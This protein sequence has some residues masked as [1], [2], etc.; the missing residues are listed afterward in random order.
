MFLG[1]KG[2]KD[3]LWVF[4][5][6]LAAIACPLLAHAGDATRCEEAYV[7][8]PAGAIL[9]LLDPDAPGERRVRALQ[10]YERLATMR[11]CPEFGY[12]L[13]QLYRHGPEL[14]GNLVGEDI[15]KAKELIQAMA[16][17]GYL[18]AFADL[19]EMVMREGEHREAMLWT[20]VYLHLVRTVQRP[21]VDADDA[22]FMRTAYN[23]HLLTRAETVWRW[24][25]PAVP[26]RRVTE[27]LNAWLSE[28]GASVH[29]RMTERQQGSDRR[30]SAQDGPLPRVLAR[31]DDC[32][33]ILDPRIGAATVS[34]IVEVL[35]TGQMGRVVLEN[36]VPRAGF[37]E[38][39]RPCLQRYRFEPFAG[40][41]P[42]TRRIS[43]VYG[44]PEGAAI[45]R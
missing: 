34:W 21:G 40:E 30:A 15:A 11:E 25:K 18:P 31:A 36:F 16:M 3:R 10:D 32:R 37:V 6:L 43:L 29:K 5:M 38:G 41:A 17:D 22:Q 33:L 8:L 45:R 13:G 35:P 42:V 28:H 9:D 2:M 1:G 24:Q 7:A 19:A 27:D 4:A 44:S 23:G 20:Q 12:T 26:R 39:L 14:P